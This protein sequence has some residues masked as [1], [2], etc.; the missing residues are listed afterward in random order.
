MLLADVL[1]VRTYASF[2]QSRRAWARLFLHG[3]TGNVRRLVRRAAAL[4][5]LAL[6]G[7][8]AIAAGAAT[9]SMPTLIIGLLA[10][11]AMI[12][13][14]ALVYRQARLPI[15]YAL[16]APFAFLSTAVFLALAARDGWSERPIEWHGAR[17]P[18]GVR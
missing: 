10:T 4:P 3:A 12:V 13:A 6:A 15:G 16:L 5:F 14:A 11:S 9:A 18:G 1:R 7:P 2:T 8:A 17:Y